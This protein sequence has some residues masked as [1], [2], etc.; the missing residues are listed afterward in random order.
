[1][2]ASPYAFSCS[3]VGQFFFHL[4]SL[5]FPVRM[6]NSRE[7]VNFQIAIQRLLAD[8]LVAIRRQT[9]DKLVAIRR[10]VTDE[11]V[12]LRRELADGLLAIRTE[13]A[14]FRTNINQLADVLQSSRLADDHSIPIAANG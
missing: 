8:E 6:S 2:T 12:A 7:I 9:T 5:F 13:Q 10:K 3:S 14:Q 4:T 11:L 1:M